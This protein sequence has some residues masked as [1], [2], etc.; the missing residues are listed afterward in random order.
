[1]ATACAFRVIH[2]KPYSFICSRQVLY[3]AAHVRRKARRPA[4][5]VYS[6]RSITAKIVWY[7]W[8]SFRKIEARKL[9]SCDRLVLVFEM[10]VHVDEAE[11]I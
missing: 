9:D 7:R 11:F 2:G 10:L 5:A 1:V 4:P 3:G 6:T 8:L